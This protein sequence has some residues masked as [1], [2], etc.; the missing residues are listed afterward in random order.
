[1]KTVKSHPDV[2]EEYWGKHYDVYMIENTIEGTVYTLSVNGHLVR[3]K[4]EHL[5]Q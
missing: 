1:M 5:E 3:F 4:K 2:P